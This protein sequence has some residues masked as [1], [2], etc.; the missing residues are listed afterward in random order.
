M[1]RLFLS[2]YLERKKEEQLAVV[3]LD[4]HSPEKL[5]APKHPCIECYVPARIPEKPE[6][7]ARPSRLVMT[8]K[9]GCILNLC[10]H[11]PSPK[12]THRAKTSR[13]HPPERPNVEDEANRNASRLFLL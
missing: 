10:I 5:Q 7:R 11:F 8:H 3:M 6:P 13:A 12:L 4:T 1:I 2:V 9:P